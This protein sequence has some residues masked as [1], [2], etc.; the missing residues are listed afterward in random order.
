MPANA[1]GIEKNFL[2]NV[3]AGPIR[4]GARCS[5]AGPV[6]PP[7]DEGVDGVI[8]VLIGAS[9]SGRELGRAGRRAGCTR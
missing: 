7:A 8:V 4:D 9:L 1:V 6:G 5:S 3:S 2:A